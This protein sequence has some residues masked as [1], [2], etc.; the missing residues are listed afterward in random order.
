MTGNGTIGRQS[1][2]HR[3]GLLSDDFNLLIRIT[4]PTKE[5]NIVSTIA[6]LAEANMKRWLNKEHLAQKKLEQDKD[7]EPGPFVVISR[8][9]GAR[10]EEIGS[11]FAKNVNWDM[12]DREFVDFVAKDQNVSSQIVENVDEKHRNWLT[13][14]F[15]TWLEG[16]QFNQETYL[17]EV[18]KLLLVAAQHGKFVAIGRGAQFILPRKKGLFVLLQ[19]PLKQRTECIAASRSISID[20]AAKVIKQIEKER[21]EFFQNNFRHDGYD[22]KLFDLV[23]DTSQFDDEKACEILKLAA[24]SKLG[25]KF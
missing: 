16:K 18:Q 4:I 20:E 21:N 15:E 10:G 9:P 12:I 22:P 3:M 11:L 24:N 25:L 14:I 23:I 13:E 6:R 7:L 8:E 17:Q 5:I 1:R 19:A 2:S